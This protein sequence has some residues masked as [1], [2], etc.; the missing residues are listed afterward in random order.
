MGEKEQL[1]AVIAKQTKELADNAEI[2]TTMNS[3]KTISEETIDT[4]RN[5]MR[6]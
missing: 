5:N 6:A 4:T 2:I 1:Q 3:I